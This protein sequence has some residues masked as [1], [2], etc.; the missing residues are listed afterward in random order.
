MQ[1]CGSYCTKKKRKTGTQKSGRF[2]R[3]LADEKKETKK[4]GSLV[5]N[6]IR[7]VD[8]LH[9]ITGS[10]RRCGPNMRSLSEAAPF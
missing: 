2:S 6:A 8:L 1:P 3:T 10:N 5:E 4:R 7:K 9:L